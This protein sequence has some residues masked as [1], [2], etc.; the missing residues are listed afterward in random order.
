MITGEKHRCKKVIR[1]V[2]RE[3]ERKGRVKIDVG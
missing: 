3:S 1:D 2:W